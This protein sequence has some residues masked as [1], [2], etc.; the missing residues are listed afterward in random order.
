MSQI[1]KST[2]DLLILQTLGLGPNHGFGIARSIGRVIC[3]EMD[4]N[5]G[6][7]F[8]ALYRLE[9]R[10]WLASEWTESG[11]HP[12]AKFY[13]ITTQGRKQIEAETG[14]SCSMLYAQITLAVVRSTLPGLAEPPATRS[15]F[16]IDGAMIRRSFLTPVQLYRGTAFRV[17]TTVGTIER[18]PFYGAAVVLKYVTDP[19]SAFRVRRLEERLECVYENYT[20]GLPPHWSVP[21]SV[22]EHGVWTDVL[23]FGDERPLPADI[24]RIVRQELLLDGKVFSVN[25]IT[26]RQDGVEFDPREPDRTPKLQR[27]LQQYRHRMSFER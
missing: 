3:G 27:K 12:R 11:V 13:R 10:A 21:F 2:L 17:T 7:L 18:K 23:A 20:T 24:E 14:S 25:T 8:A 1:H 19:P 5:P 16:V 22:D 26:F 9:E 4:V 6:S 15:A